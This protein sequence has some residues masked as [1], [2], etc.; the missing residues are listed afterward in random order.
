M[1]LHASVPCYFFN[2][3]PELHGALEDMTDCPNAVSGTQTNVTPWK[4]PGE[5]LSVLKEVER[6]FVL[7]KHDC[8]AFS[9]HF[10]RL[11]PREKCTSARTK[12]WLKVQ[13]E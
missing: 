7:A 2:M 12:S 1:H 13:A 5:V 9:L 10:S 4:V 8:F 11:L 3:V 6:V